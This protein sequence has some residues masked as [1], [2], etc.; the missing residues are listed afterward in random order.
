MDDAFDR[1]ARSSPSVRNVPTIVVSD[2]N[3]IDVGDLFTLPPS[4]TRTPSHVTH[5]N[6]P[7]PSHPI[8]PA[9]SALPTAP[10]LSE[11]DS[12]CEK[13][14]FDRGRGCSRTSSEQIHSLSCLS[15]AA[16]H[17]IETE[18]IPD[19]ELRQT[20]E[21]VSAA[22]NDAVVHL[23]WLTNQRVADQ[24]AWLQEKALLEIQLKNQTQ[25][26]KSFMGLQ[27]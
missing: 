9:T 19:K 23:H 5:P 6:A 2:V 26:L 21:L 8:Q 13:S 11:S 16:F 22:F 27:H 15:D 12:T 1:K 20:L 18:S 14:L 3:D 10:V 24:H 7:P 17:A 4:R 25:I